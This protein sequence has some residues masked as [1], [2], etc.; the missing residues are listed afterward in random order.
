MKVVLSTRSWNLGFYSLIKSKTFTNRESS[1]FIKSI[2][3]FHIF[4]WVV[5]ITQVLHIGIASN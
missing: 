2:L 1:S 3:T 5:Y 4:T